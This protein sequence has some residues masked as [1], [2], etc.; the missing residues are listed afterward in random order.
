MGHA[1]RS[2]AIIRK[3][4]ELN[5]EIVVRNSNVVD[6]LQK[7]L[8]QTT[9]LSGITDMGPAIKNNGIS[10]NQTKAKTQIGKWISQFHDTVNEEKEIITKI[11]PHLIISDISAMPFLVAKK[12]NKSSIAIS[13]FSWYDTLK[14]LKNTDLEVLRNAYDD[15]NL[16]IQ[17]PLGTQMEHFKTKN[18]VGFVTRTPTK[19]REMI[20][21]QLGIN[22]SQLVVLFALGGS[23]RELICKNDDNVTILSVDTKLKHA[24]NIIYVSKWIE[25]QDLVAASDLVICKCGYGI[26]S[27]CL[28]NG[29]PFHYVMDDNHLEQRSISKELSN[30][31]FENRITFDKID[32]LYLDDEYVNSF[33][34]PKKETIDTNSVVRYISEF[35]TH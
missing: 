2:V 25:G 26:I 13:N 21:K 5:I 10:I 17:L 27:E 11:Q 29:I 24:N 8:P 34:H 15:A 4:Q 23:T 35:L 20:R 28:T 30:R 16:A 18:K 9:I 7:S 3:L 19:S 22:N 1:T 12:M 33:F 32:S 6:F 14:F 31:G